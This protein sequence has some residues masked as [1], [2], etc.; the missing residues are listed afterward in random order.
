MLGPTKT[1][2]NLNKLEIGHQ[3]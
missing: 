2:I 1:I 3:L